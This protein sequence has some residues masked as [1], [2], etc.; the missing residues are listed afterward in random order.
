MQYRLLGNTGISVSEFCLGA[1]PMGP[2][3]SDISVKEGAR[4]IRLALERGINFVDTA[5]MYKTYPHI[6]AALDGFSGEVVI[7]SKSVA[8]TYEEMEQAV[9]EALRELGRDDI[10]IFLLHAARVLPDVF[11][12]RAG[13]WECLQEYKRKGYIRAI[14][15]STHNVHTVD[16]A[17]DLPELDI[18]FP[19]INY[20]GLGI[21]DGNKDTMLAAIA[22]AAKAGKG[23]YAMKAL[24]GGALLTELPQA[25]EFARNIPGIASVALGIT[26]EAELLI[27]LK[28][29]NGEELNE[30]ELATLKK[31]KQ[32]TFMF[33]CRGC[34]A[35]AEGCVN[36]AITMVE[37]RPRVDVN[38]CVLCGYCTPHCPEFAIRLR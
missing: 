23:L 12:K 1:L 27:D 22:R 3:Q 24:A 32:L 31:N 34:G 37:G 25:L 14:G 18:I 19:L 11:E 29:F 16:A 21:L 28:L 8:S 7:N 5:Q 4:I 17:A 6:R 20:K 15:I 26:T 2:L 30:Q 38:K 35:C 10:D 9:W 13:A 36:G 33:F